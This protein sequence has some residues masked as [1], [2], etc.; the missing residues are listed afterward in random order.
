MISALIDSI[1][2]VDTDQMHSDQRPAKLWEN[3]LV[4]LQAGNF[5][6]IFYGGIWKSY[7]AGFINTAVH[8]HN[9]Q[10]DHLGKE[11]DYTK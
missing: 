2:L 3:E 10:T 11:V 1:H 5:V 7:R 6:V 8:G 4:L 9:K